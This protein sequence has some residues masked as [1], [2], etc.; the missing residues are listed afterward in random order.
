MSTL[1]LVLESVAIGVSFSGG[2]VACLLG[3]SIYTARARK[4]DLSQ[5]ANE[6]A[7]V[8]ERC[9]RSAI[10]NELSSKALIRIA[11]QLESNGR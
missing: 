11:D 9:L 3:V 8:A 4:K 10:A 2:A 6:N 7:K 1:N 5:I